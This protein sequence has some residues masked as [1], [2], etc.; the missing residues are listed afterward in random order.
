MVNIGIFAPH[1]KRMILECLK[2]MFAQNGYKYLSVS[3]TLTHDTLQSLTSSDIPYLFLDL[4]NVCIDFVDIL[5]LDTTVPAEVQQA[6]KYICPS[7]HLIY[8]VDNGFPLL[9]HPHAV[10]YG[11]SQ[12][13]SA[14]ISSVADS[15][16]IFCL[17]SPVITL[18]EN[19][20]GE[21]EI[22][23]RTGENP[24]LVAHFL[25]AVACGI[26]C[27]IIREDVVII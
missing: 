19:Y 26:L 11:L 8:N 27:E 4:E 20:V 6:I 24:A 5:I 9:S 13:A 15:D 22:L 10:S 3:H 7:T 18:C 17:Q 23:V 12:H 2:E 25:P 21:G 14:T 1:S 16:F